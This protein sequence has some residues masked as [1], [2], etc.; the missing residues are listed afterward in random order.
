MVFD[1]VQNNIYQFYMFEIGHEF[2]QIFTKLLFILSVRLLNNALIRGDSCQFV[3]NYFLGFN[4]IILHD[5][6]L[7]RIFA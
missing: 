4:I 1:W 2:T 6:N 3:A 5:D 7:I